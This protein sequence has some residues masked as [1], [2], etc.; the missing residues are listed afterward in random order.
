MFEV[1]VKVKVNNDTIKK[2]L[3]S[4]GCF[5][6]ALKQNDYIFVHKSVKNGEVPKGGNI[7]RIR[8]QNNK[9]ILT[10]KQKGNLFDSLELETGVDSIKAMTDILSC[11]EY[12]LIVNVNKKRETTRYN[13]MVICFDEVE[14]LGKFIEAEIIVKT[15]KEMP[16]ALNKIMSFYK[17][18]G[19]TENDICK[20]RYDDMVYK[21]NKQ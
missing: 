15:E 10:L 2:F 6:K 20:E 1:E 8:T 9:N 18:F 14:S 11:M 17:Q 5:D 19:I 12:N 13:G 3:K 16:E 21:L 4:K 7:L